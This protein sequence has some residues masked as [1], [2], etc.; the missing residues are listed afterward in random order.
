MI[1]LLSSYVFW[2]V[3]AGVGLGFGTA[4]YVYR[5][6][7][8][9]SKIKGAEEYSAKILKDAEKRLRQSAKNLT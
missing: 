1:S 6:Y 9:E 8:A 7:R 4:G 3:T 5:K 2:I